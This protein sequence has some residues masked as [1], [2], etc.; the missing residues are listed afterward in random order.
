MPGRK[1][2][3]RGSAK[4]VGAIEANPGALEQA[5]TAYES[6][7]Y[8]ASSRPPM[9]SRLRWWFERA[10][11]KGW[12]PYP[13]T[14]PKIAYIGAVLKAAGYRS[15]KLYLEVIKKEHVRL[16]GWTEQLGLELREAVASCQR[17]LGPARQAGYVALEQ[18]LAL[19]CSIRY[20]EVFNGF[21][22]P[23][24]SALVAMH[25]A[26][27]EIEISAVRLGAVW[28]KEGDGCGL[29]TLDLPASKADTLALGAPRTHGCCC[30]NPGC[31]VAAIKELFSQAEKL[32][33]ALTPEAFE[34]R[35]LAPTIDGGFATKQG[36]VACFRGLG[37]LIDPEV[38]VTGHM[39]RVACAIRMAKAGL[40]VWK[41]Q[42]FC[43]WG[44]AVVLRYIR[45]APLE[46]SHLW[47][48]QV[49]KGLELKDVKAEMRD[50]KLATQGLELAMQAWKP[51]LNQMAGELQA[52][53]KEAESG[54]RHLLEG[55]GDRLQ[56][57]EDLPARTLPRYVGNA[58][59]HAVKLRV[60]RNHNVTFCGW[61][62][63]G[64]WFAAPKEH[65]EPGEEVCA[66]CSRFSSEP[67]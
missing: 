17:G 28:F 9:D 51:A 20:P 22:F 44:S 16:H 62:W 2:Y 37:R 40:D 53:A 12:D 32:K 1:A 13:L 65:R 45:S 3:V 4:A 29:A 25:W 11:R 24:L 38:R 43:R 14:Q 64:N 26:L 56:A 50:T 36:A 15:A 49:A 10:K 34:L 59:P 42:L 67:A 6:E 47:A 35:P 60:P 41:I 55:V 54:W 31:P 57:L 46:S 30:P 5:A 66:R 48:G 8:A 52:Q 39:P 61:T 21:A 27:R 63:G 18:V 23:R 58:S 7:K 33:G 19:D